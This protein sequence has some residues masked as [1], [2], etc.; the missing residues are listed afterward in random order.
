MPG[1]VALLVLP[2]PNVAKAPAAEA[3]KS[4]I[5]PVFLITLFTIEH[6]CLFI[7]YKN[8]DK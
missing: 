6:L 8:K 7:R 4:T 5:A 3:N 1:R 2:S